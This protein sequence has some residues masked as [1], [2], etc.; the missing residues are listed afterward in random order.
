MNPKLLQLIPVTL[1][2]MQ[3]AETLGGPGTGP[4][5]R[6]AVKQGIKTIAAGMTAVSEGGQKDTWE[7]IGGLIDSLSVFF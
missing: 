7:G 2:L 4:Q 1:Q 3:V 6:E 5:K